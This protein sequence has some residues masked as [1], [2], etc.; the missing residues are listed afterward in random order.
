MDFYQSDLRHTISQ[1]IYRKP[2]FD[3]SFNEKEYRWITKQQ[4]KLWQ[5]LKRYM[6]HG[7][8]FENNHT[9]VEIEKPNELVEQGLRQIR[10]D[11][12]KGRG[13]IFFQF[14]FT[15]LIGQCPTHELKD[16]ATVDIFI[17]QKKILRDQLFQYHKLVPSR[18][19]HMPD[20]TI[21][22][23]LKK[24]ADEARSGYSES[25]KRYI[26]KWKKESLDFHI[27]DESERESFYNIWYTMAYDKWF[28]VLPRET[29]LALMK[30]LTE[31]NKGRL[32]LATKWWQPVSGS[33]C[34]KLGDD[35]V[36]LY[37]A[38]DR[39]FWDIGW[40]YR[41][42][43]KIAER[44]HK[45]GLVHFDLLGVA[46]PDATGDHPLIWVTRFKQAFGGQT[47]IYLWNYDLV[48]NPW[49]YQAFQWRRS[50]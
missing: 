37:G 47:H 36:Y 34:V 7:M 27:A 39:S 29:F 45:E 22:L 48:F 32:F 38:T 43:H 15:D 35:L 25:G 16:K 17:Q 4:Q 31:K 6:A 3:F 42:T 23:D 18:R 21:V 14:W 1:E 46:P 2:V 10:R 26:N 44:W 9:L 30:R 41:L 28:F 50:G 12:R 13:D 8:R 11:F 20:T 40:H 24:T 49:M 33:I 19:R 5:S